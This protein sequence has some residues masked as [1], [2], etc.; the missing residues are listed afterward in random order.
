MIQDLTFKVRLCIFTLNKKTR[1]IM[2]YTLDMLKILQEELFESKK[3]I[4]THLVENEDD[5]DSRYEYMVTCEEYSE[6]C[7]EIK[8]RQSED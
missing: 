7:E 2:K 6:V 5:I 4:L 3:E 8:T 1:D